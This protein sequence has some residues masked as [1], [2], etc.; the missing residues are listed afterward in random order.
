[1]QAQEANRLLLAV[2]DE[3][4]LMAGT[5]VLLELNLPLLL[6]VTWISSRQLANDVLF[7]ASR[8]IRRLIA[9]FPYLH[10]LSVPC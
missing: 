3:L 1:M 6:A 2:R 9:H 7:L 5:V 10:D 8:Q 4:M